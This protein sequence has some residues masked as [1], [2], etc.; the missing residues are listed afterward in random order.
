MEHHEAERLLLST[1]SLALRTLD[2]LH[3]A[4]ALS[5][6]AT[7][8]VTY[9]VRMRAAAAQAGLKVVEVA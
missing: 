2:A 6:P 7:H 9:D 8:V 4:L 5:G 3:V 1:D